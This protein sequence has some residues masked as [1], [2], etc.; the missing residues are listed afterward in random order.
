MIDW[1]HQMTFCRL[2]ERVIKLVTMI[3]NTIR[4]YSR[5]KEYIEETCLKP[6]IKNMLSLGKKSF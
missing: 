4:F 3:E 6:K 1:L 5:L 2:N